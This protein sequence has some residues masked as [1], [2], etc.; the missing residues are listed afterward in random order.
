[1]LDLIGTDGHRR[2]SSDALDSAFLKA[3][4]F[5][6]EWRQLAGANSLCSGL[7]FDEHEA[8]MIVSYNHNICDYIHYYYLI[9][10]YI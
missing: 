1:M 6:G 8:I 5:M 10:F 3:K 9:L 2:R 4:A 7:L